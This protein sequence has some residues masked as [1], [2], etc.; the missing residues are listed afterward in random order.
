MADITVENGSITNATIVN[1]GSGYQTGDVLSIDTIGNS[2]VGR[3]CR[4]SIATIGDPNELILDNV[5]GEFVSGSSNS[6]FYTNN[7]GNLVELDESNGGGVLVS[8]VNVDSDGL[9]VKVNHKN[10]GMYFEDNLVRIV[11][12]P[13]RY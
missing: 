6:I 3:N 12:K 11:G 7:L 1:G 13:I 9:H 5:Q 2:S 8:S 4:L 10:H